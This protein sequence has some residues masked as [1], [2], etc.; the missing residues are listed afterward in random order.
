MKTLNVSTKTLQDFLKLCERAEKLGL[1]FKK[2]KSKQYVILMREAP[3]SGLCAE[4]ITWSLT[5]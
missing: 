1:L 3:L 5:T 2:D 4:T